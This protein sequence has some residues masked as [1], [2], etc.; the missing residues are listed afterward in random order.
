MTYE[1]PQKR[2]PHQLTV[3]QHIFP[4]FCVKQF[5]NSNNRVEL[6]DKNTNKVSYVTGSDSLFCAK[7]VWDQS[8]ESGYMKSI[9]DKYE[10][11]LKRTYHKVTYQ[12]SE[13]DQITVGE[14]F[15]LWMC[16][17]QRANAPIPD[18][19]LKNIL[20]P[21][22]E[23]SFGK[24]QLEQLEKIG[25]I[26]MRS[27]GYISGR[28]FNGTNIQQKIM[29]YKLLHKHLKWG[30]LHSSNAEFI[31]PDT[32]EDIAVLPISPKICFAL[33]VASGHISDDQVF[34][35]NNIARS[36]SKKFYFARDMSY[37]F[38]DTSYKIKTIAAFQ[39][40]VVE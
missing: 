21:K 12:I 11:M 29:E 34:Q 8:S 4:N 20:P 40:K 37:C 6:F 33:H 39:K 16:R 18:Q 26:S 15:F 38:A 13:Q 2:N 22:P 17:Y 3:K 28:F 24:D 1:K 35:I 9:E 14:M 31:V 5:Y 10:D 36:K 27:D 30:V 23:D 32:Y 25:V 7:R 19:V